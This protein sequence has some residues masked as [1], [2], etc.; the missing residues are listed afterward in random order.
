VDDASRSAT[1]TAPAPPRAGRGPFCR[2][3][4]AHW[5]RLLRGRPAPTGWSPATA[6]RPVSLVEAGRCC[7]WA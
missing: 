2:T 6:Q 7:R 1:D 4:T 5:R 3:P